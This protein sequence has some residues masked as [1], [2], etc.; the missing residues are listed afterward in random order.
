MLKEI[1]YC[2]FC[3]FAKR[4][5]GTEDAVLLISLYLFINV[6]TII[7]ALERILNIK[8]L[9]FFPK[10]SKGQFSSWIIMVLTML[11]FVLFVYKRYFTS[12]KLQSLHEEYARKSERRL[13]LG[14]IL[15]CSYLI[16]TWVLFFVIV[17]PW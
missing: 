6:L 1:A 5:K 14:R 15:V 7:R 4:Q 16:L 12:Q 9:D 8:I 11:P 13:H 17:T 3:F 10:V 2:V